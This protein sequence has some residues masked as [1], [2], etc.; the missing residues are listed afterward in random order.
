[1]R[2]AIL[3]VYENF[4]ITLKDWNNVCATDIETDLY[5]D[6]IVEEGELLHR[7]YPYDIL[8]IMRERTPFPR[9]LIE[10]LPNL[11]LLVTTGPANRTID[12]T[13]C[14]EKGIVVCGTESSKNTTAELCWALILA[15]VRKIPQHDGR[16]RK[17]MWEGNVP[18]CSLNGKVLGVVGLGNLGKQV[19]RI[20]LAFG[21]KVIAWSQNL[22]TGEA[23]AVGVDWVEKDELFATADIISIH[24]V[25]SGRTEGLVGAR[26]IALMKSSAYIINTSRGPIIEEKALIDALKGNHIGGAGLDVFAEEPL[27][28]SHPLLALH[29]TVVTPHIGY[30]TKDNFN[31]FFTQANEDVA[32]WLAG[33]P[34]R[35]LSS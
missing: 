14:S 21:M 26:E 25:L 19:A 6:H 2:L 13:A 10:Q 34:I 30:V 1:M 12:L 8:V 3:D 20:G 16:L 7:L 15:T 22:T 23:S 31:T 5:R 32:A 35:V 18:G 24:L 9:S 27:P 4:S 29:N 17:G 11:K 28:S 33:K